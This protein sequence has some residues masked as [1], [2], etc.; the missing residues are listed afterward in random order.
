MLFFSILT[1]YITIS[2][3][4]VI[5]WRISI[6]YTISKIKGF[7][8]ILGLFVTKHS[9][10]KI[11]CK[12]I[13]LILMNMNKREYAICLCEREKK[14]QRITVILNYHN[15]HHHQQYNNNHHITNNAYD[16][17]NMCSTFNVEI[18]S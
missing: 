13:I 6:A 4:A 16:I 1:V 3:M 12:T 8:L 2:H 10:M 17:R 7:C 15:H 5:I 9:F 18:R 14:L 11:Q